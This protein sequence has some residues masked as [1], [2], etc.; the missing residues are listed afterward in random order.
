[1][2]I[3]TS[4]L[5]DTAST[6]LA[7]ARSSRATADRGE[8]ELLVAAC[9][10]ADLH[11]ASSVL[12]A[13]AFMLGGS[14]HEEPI[15]GPGAPLV[16]EFCIAEFGAVLGISTVTAKHLIGQAIEL[17]HRLPRLWRRVQAGDLPAW[18]AR[19]IAETTIHATLSHEAAS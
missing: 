16:A 9:E 2:A 8:A 4:E 19:R 3:T 5:P 10:W 11:P 12:D 15:A 6:V 14:E 13:A 17:R 1:M 18:R 7:F